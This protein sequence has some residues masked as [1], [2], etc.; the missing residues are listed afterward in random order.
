MAG[1]RIDAPDL[2]VGA[3]GLGLMTVSGTATVGVNGASADIVV[4]DLTDNNRTNALMV[5][6]GVVTVGDNIE[7]GDASN[8]R[9]RLLLSGGS[10][11]VTGRSSSAMPPDLPARWR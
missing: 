7:L 5:S 4:G 6:G 2:F 8:T 11:I 9:G 3:K 10:V 1:G